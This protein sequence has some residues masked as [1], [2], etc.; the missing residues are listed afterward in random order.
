MA[1]VWATWVRF[2][3]RV[4]VGDRIRSTE[5]QRTERTLRCELQISNEK[6]D[7]ISTKRV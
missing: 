7:K 3:V 2:R 5:A 6:I 4:R 1:R